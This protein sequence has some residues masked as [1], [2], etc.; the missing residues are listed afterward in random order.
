M[1]D[2]GLAQSLHALVAA[3]DLE[4]E[5]LLTERFGITHS[6]LA[7]LAPLLQAEALD[8][9]SLAAAMRVS[10]PAVSK[11]TAWFVE[12]S[13]VQVD[14]ASAKG[15]RV[16]LSL[17][18]EGR[19]LASE[20]IAALDDGLTAL[21]ADFPASRRDE[22]FTLVLELLDHVRAQVV[23]PPLSERTH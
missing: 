14:G 2:A 15:R 22:F 23:V 6:Q 13:L 3:L 20:A 1:D 21:L 7:F 9:S 19:R 11:R 18:P 5:R 4:A 17:T 8:V 10:V 16:L 12:R